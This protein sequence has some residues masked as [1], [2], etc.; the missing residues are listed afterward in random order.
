[1]NNQAFAGQLYEVLGTPVSTRIL[2]VLS[3]KQL[4]LL[5]YRYSLVKHA[6]RMEEQT[7]EDWWEEEKQ[8]S[9][10]TIKSILD[11]GKKKLPK[12][13]YREQTNFYLNT[14]YPKL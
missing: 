9:I 2:D 7:G 11:F 14:K 1:M 6:M 8:E 10:A 12:K 3:E 5:A 4:H 13:A